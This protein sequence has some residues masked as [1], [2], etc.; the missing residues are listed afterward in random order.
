M[1]QAIV[2][3]VLVLPRLAA[4]IDAGEASIATCKASHPVYLF[5]TPF[6]HEHDKR[7]VVNSETSGY[8]PDEK[9]TGPKYCL[10]GFCTYWT[11]RRD[12]ALVMRN[13]TAE[14]V[15]GQLSQLPEFIS[16]LKTN[17]RQEN[18]MFYESDI[19]GKGIGLIAKRP[20]RK[21]EIVMK[22][23]PSL[24]VQVET[25]ARID[26]DLRDRLYSHAMDR[27]RERDRSLV[28]GMMGSDLG[29][30]ID[31][32]CFRLRTNEVESDNGDGGD[33]YIGCYPD[34]ARLNHDCRPR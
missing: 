1:Y 7:C 31:K 9:W 29:D 33:H 20:I 8:E 27:M 30:K 32:N 17:E 10:S 2:A 24:L 22:R 21:G 15:I 19:P 4:T 34:V 13:S 14:Q 6:G 11:R 23:Q 26:V 12:F 3:F 18:G 28:M 25:Q 16:S 5:E